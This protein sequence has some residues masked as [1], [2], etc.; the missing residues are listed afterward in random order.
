[1]RFTLMRLVLLVFAFALAGS[2]LAQSNDYVLGPGDVIAIKVFQNVDLSVESRVSESGLISYPLI[3][4]VKVAGL[5]AS[6]AGALITRQ[7]MDGKFVA[8]PY[9]TVAVVQYRSIQVSVLGQVL[10]PG[11]YPLEQSVNRVTDVLALAGGVT[12]VGADTVWVITHQNGAE[13]KLDVDVPAMMASGDTA[14]NVVV[15]NG[16]TV[17]VPRAPVFYIYGEAQH[18]GQYRIE[19]DMSV[20]QALAVGGGPTTRGTDRGLRISR[21][22]AGGQ[23]VTREANPNEP[24]QSDDVLYV[25]E[26]L[27]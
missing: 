23:L 17:F 1:M 16:D 15:R 22:D 3:G 19:R 25:R 27:F 6:D 24:V 26:R 10:R 18:P 11:K 5:S 12:P 21:R 7:L 13:R 2:A 9:V 20:M 4:D 14:K 8:H